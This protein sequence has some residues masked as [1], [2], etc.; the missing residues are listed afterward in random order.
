MYIGGSTRSID[1]PTPGALQPQSAGN[2][3]GAIAKIA[4]VTAPTSTPQP[5]SITFSDVPVGSTFYPYVHYLACDGIVRGY[6]DGTFRPDNNTTRGQLARIV[7]NAAG[8]ANHATLQV[9]EDVPTSSPFFSQ[10]AELASRGVIVGYP[11]DRA[12]ARGPEGTPLMPCVPPLNRPYFEPNA[13]VTRGQAAKIAALTAAW[14][15]PANQQSFQ[16]VPT[17]HTFYPWIEEMAALGLIS[18]YPCGGPGEPCV[19]PLNLPYF[20][21]AATT[22]RGQVSKIAANT[23]Y[24]GIV[25]QQS[26][27]APR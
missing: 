10:T 5:C 1:F 14:S 20:R 11:C 24:P 21:P 13:N 4:P 19:P 16:D 8:Y 9:F 23:F 26:D 2:D 27:I 25:Q 17:S 15:P 22:T 6:V 18:G 12:V 7:S 3:E